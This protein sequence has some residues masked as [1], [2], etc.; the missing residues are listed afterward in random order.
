MRGSTMNQ[1]DEGLAAS[2]AC[3]HTYTKPRTGGAY[4]THS[5]TCECVS[6]DDLLVLFFSIPHFDGWLVGANDYQEKMSSGCSVVRMA[7]TTSPRGDSPMG[8]NM[9]PIWP[10]LYS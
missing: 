4:D 8:F 6:S 2:S 9:Q 3:N 5:S 7:L 10:S 1:K